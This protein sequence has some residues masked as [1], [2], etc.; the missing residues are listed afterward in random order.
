MRSNKH[1]RDLHE[2]KKFLSADEA[3][4]MLHE[5]RHIMGLTDDEIS[6]FCKGLIVKNERYEASGR[7]TATRYWLHHLNGEKR[8]K[9][10]Q[11]KN[12]NIVI[13]VPVHNERVERIHKLIRSI[14]AQKEI[15]S[16]EYEVILVVNNARP[17]ERQNYEE[18]V[19]NNSKVITEVEKLGINN[20]YVIDK[21]SIGNEIPDCN[22]G[23]ARNR[24]LAEASIRFFES[25]KN[26]VII[27]T[28]ADTYYEDEFFLSKVKQLMSNNQIVG[29]SG[30]AIFEFT[31]DEN[32]PESVPILKQKLERYILKKKWDSLILLKGKPFNPNIFYGPNMISRSYE[33]ASIGGFI[34]TNLLEDTQFGIDLTKYAEK[35]GMRVISAKSELVAITSIR[36]SQRTVST[37]SKALNKIDLNKPEMVINPQFSGKTKL[38]MALWHLASPLTNYMK[39]EL[40]EAS[41][42]HLESLVLKEPRGP[43]LVDHINGTVS[44]IRIP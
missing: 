22:V 31:P 33:S 21:S 1:S 35:N 36:N 17:L 4:G 15:D 9:P 34:D 13:L 24:G 3:K 43:E 44:A 5:L 37:F 28:D 16:S 27:H 39:I 11:T 40:T 38:G 7:E 12:C 10:A 29:V 2:L 6:Q 30:G 20:I 32:D 19:F 23:K 8:I 18:I 14:A 26:G 41:Y 25:G 42:K